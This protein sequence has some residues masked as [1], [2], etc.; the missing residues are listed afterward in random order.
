MPSVNCQRVRRTTV[1]TSRR[2]RAAITDIPGRSPALIMYTS[3][4]TGR[5]RG[6]VLTHTNL[7]GRAMTHLFT[8][9]ADID[10]DIGFMFIGVP[11]FH[12][13]GIGNTVFGLLLG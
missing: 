7:A 5:P 8:N 1:S 3:G 11:L 2:R 12:I 10:N 9:S 6:A 4:T 13:A